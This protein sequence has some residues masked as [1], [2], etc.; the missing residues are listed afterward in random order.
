MLQNQLIET[1]SD[2]IDGQANTGPL[3]LASNHN[4][5]HPK[6]FEHLGLFWSEPEVALT[7]LSGRTRS[8]SER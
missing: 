8:A 7:D 1:P 5:M 2:S 3:N 6:G 4:P